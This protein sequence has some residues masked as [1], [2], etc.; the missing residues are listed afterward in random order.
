MFKKILL[1][2]TLTIIILSGASNTWAIGESGSCITT[3][4][5]SNHGCNNGLFCKPS[6]EDLSRGSCERETNAYLSEGT[7]CLTFPQ[8]NRPDEQCNKIAGLQ[9]NPFSINSPFGKCEKITASGFFCFTTDNLF[10]NGCARDSFCKPLKDSPEQGTCTTISGAFI[11]EG[12]AC[13]VSPRT[14]KPDERCNEAAGYTCKPLSSDPRFGSC[15]R[16]AAAAATSAIRDVF[17]QIQPPEPIKN[18]L[19]NDQTGTTAISTFLS[20]LV[21]LFY[22]IAIIV[23]VFMFLWAAFEWMT[24]GGEKEKVASARNKILYTIIGIVLLAT[25][26]AILRIVGTFTGFQFFFGQGTNLQK[27]PQGKPRLITCP[28]GAQVNVT[29]EITDPYDYCKKRGQI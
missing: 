21:V 8:S 1:I 9:C 29:E 28:N 18:L 2:I 5:L 14:N 7:V 20:N 6:K 17:G 11:A 22:T 12:S 19:G 27:D 15:E 13:L 26:F 3:D 23:A 4:S 10:N 16:P 25:A 24:S